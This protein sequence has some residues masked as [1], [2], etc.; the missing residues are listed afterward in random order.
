M[1]L[2]VS[3]ALPGEGQWTPADADVEG[4]P[5]MYVAQFRADTVYTSQ[6]TS[7]VWIDPT[8][9]RVALVPGAQEPGGTWPQPPDIT[10][11][12]LSTAVA[13][14]N[15]GFRIQDAHGG[16]YLDGRQAVP[17]QPGAASMVIYTNGRIDIGTWGSEVTMTPQVSAVLQNLVP[18]VDHGQTAPDATYNDTQHLG[19]HP[20]RQ[21]R[22]GPLRHRRHCHRGAHLCGR[23]RAHRPQPGRIPRSGPGPCGP[24]PSTSTRNGSPST[25]TPTPIPPTP[26]P[27]IRAK[28]YPQM[29]RPADRYLGPTRIPGLLHRLAAL[30]A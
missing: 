5:A 6:I 1:P 4:A 21:H 9:L 26:A 28:L 14:F 10:G 12:A 24:W 30:P 3:P 11:S 27:S 20:G 8:R 16:F 25:S 2:V 17:L 19:R 7:A 13:A 18:I 22:G 15:G 23:P 29:Q